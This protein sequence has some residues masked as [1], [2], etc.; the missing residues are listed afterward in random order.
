MGAFYTQKI[1][2]TRD[3]VYIKKV[4]WDAAYSQPLTIVTKNPKNVLSFEIKTL[5]YKYNS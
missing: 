5:Y 2:G 4:Y 3:A 1:I